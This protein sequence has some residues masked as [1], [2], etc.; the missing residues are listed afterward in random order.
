M[1]LRRLERLAIAVAAIGVL[2]A[3]ALQCH[4]CMAIEKGDAGGAARSPQPTTQPAETAIQPPPA[5]SQPSAAEQ[6]GGV[7]TAVQGVTGLS[8]TKRDA[9]PVGLALLLAFD[10][11]LSHRREMRRLKGNIGGF[12]GKM[13]VPQGTRNSEL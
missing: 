4:G 7:N 9:L 12:T 3:C 6:T 5:V 11:W 8:Y 10:K 2:A 13:P 1:T